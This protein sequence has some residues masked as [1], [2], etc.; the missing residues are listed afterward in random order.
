MTELSPDLLQLKMELARATRR[1][2][3]RLLRRR[4]LLHT[5]AASLGVFAVLSGSAL[6]AGSAFGVINLDGGASATQVSSLPQWDGT[7]GAF[8]TATTGSGGVAS[9]AYHITGGTT[10]LGCPGTTR[11]VVVPNDVY[12]TSTQA[13]TTAELQQAVTTA[14]NHAV[15]NA[16]DISISGSGPGVT[17]QATEPG[18][19]ARATANQTAMAQ[20]RAAGLQ[21]LTSFFTKGAA[22]FGPTAS[23][24]NAVR[25][26]VRH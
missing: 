7:A 14:D 8:V 9:Y 2:H 5:G 25:A 13:L 23:T 3:A 22:C 12:I 1:D 21:T 11:S 10:R 20:L 15:L 19:A 6:A 17:A 16:S 18:A 4:N 24:S 26:G